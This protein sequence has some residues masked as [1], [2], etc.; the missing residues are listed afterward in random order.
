M[1][2]ALYASGHAVIISELVYCP[3]KQENIADEETLRFAEALVEEF[4]ELGDT[5]RVWTTL[6]RHH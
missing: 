6:P 1:S 2:S 3:V 5:M 4:E